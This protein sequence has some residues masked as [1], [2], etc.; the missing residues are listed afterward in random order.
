VR[1]L[2]MV[3]DASSS[4]RVRLPHRAARLGADRLRYGTDHA[5]LA[6]RF[7]DETPEANRAQVFGSAVFGERFDWPGV[8]SVYDRLRQ[9]DDW[10]LT[11]VAQVESRADALLRQAALEA[12]SGEITVPVNCGQEL[13]DVVEVTDAG[14]GL[15]AARRRV[16]AVEMRYSTGERP[17]YEQRI[18]LG[19]LSSDRAVRRKAASMAPPVAGIVVASPNAPS[20]GLLPCGASSPCA[21]PLPPLAC[22]SGLP[23]SRYP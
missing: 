7:A 20:C 22:R 17:A 19:G 14:A 2:A 11:A 9:V 15:S 1:L 16:L 10:N 13:Y 18:G 8:Q 12:M 3:P 23:S 6:G 5:L 4:R 21:L